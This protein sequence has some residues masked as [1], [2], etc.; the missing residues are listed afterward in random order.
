MPIDGNIPLAVQVP[1]AQNPLNEYGKIIQLKQLLQNGQINDLQLEQARRAMADED[2]ARQLFSGDTAPT[3][4]Q[5]Y[6]RVG[7]TRGAAIIK[8][9]NEQQTAGLARRKA[10]LE[11]DFKT[12]EF[13]GQQLGG[14]TDQPS[15]DAALSTLKANGIDTSNM[16]AQYNPATVQGY[17]AKGTSIKDRITQEH[18]KVMEGLRRDEVGVQ[19]QRWNAEQP[20][21]VAGSDAKVRANDASMLAAAAQQGPQALQAALGALP[22]ARAKAFEGLTKPEDIL[23]VGMTPAQQAT[24]DQQAA[25]A[26]NNVTEARLAWISQND[27]DPQK[28]ANAS[29]A[30]KRLDQSKREARPV[31]AATPIPGLSMQPSN[32][33]GDDYLKTLPPAV[34]NQVRAISEGRDVMPSPNSRAPGAAQIRNAVYQFDPSFNAQRAQ[35]RKAFT[36][37][38]DGRNIG[39]L[40]TAAVHLG[41]MVQASEAMK[42][43]SWQPGNALYN[44]IAEKFGSDKPT[45]YRFVMNAFAGEAANA[46]KGQATDPEIAHVMSTLNQDMAPEQARGIGA[47]GL[48]TLGAKLNTYDERYHQQ[49]TPDDQ[50]SPILPSAKAVFQAYGQNPITRTAGAA[51]GAPA[52]APAR[53]P[54][55]PVGTVKDGYVFRGGDPAD[56]N[57]WAKVGGGQ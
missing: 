45:N 6:A 35:L 4:Q 12:T 36:T 39:N 9:L 19:Q 47:E 17:I 57:N 28:R 54:A 51:G 16:S 26:Q 15:Y 14:V 42:N 11:N 22:Y 2:A 13:I 31:I 37:G 44:Y 43:G 24:A 46:L 27:P 29:A 23:R 34:Q 18:N 32:L 55:P 5:I 10:A 56:K 53:K 52:A 30:L 3:A 41:Q 38:P 7:P 20:G 1:Q 40:N 8:G 50:W 25:N 49:S 33:T 21:V 48:R